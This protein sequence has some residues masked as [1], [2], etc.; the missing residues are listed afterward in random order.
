MNIISLILSLLSAVV[1]I[2]TI[3]CFIDIIMS[4]FPG[5]KFT[6]FG[7]FISKVCDPYLNFFSKKGL[8]RIG[9][10]DFSPI[11]SIGILSLLSSIL[12]GITTTGTV[13][14]GRILGSI[15][16]MIWSLG[17]T[18]LT[19]LFILTLVRWI[20]LLVKNGQTDYNSG[21]YQVDAMIQRFCYKVSYTFTKKNMSY[22]KSLLINWIVY[23]ATLSVCS[24][25]FRILVSL[26]YR[27]PF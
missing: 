26:C 20:V 9:N 16:N 11:I 19:V 7:K 2:Y 17:S 23:L 25:L 27:I 10:I 8:M 15:I 12:G 24:V 21:W 22:Q 6:G 3:L 13:S 4:W 5:L 18:M 1:V 14:F